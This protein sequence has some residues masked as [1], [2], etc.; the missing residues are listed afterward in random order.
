MAAVSPMAIANGNLASLI[1]GGCK[2][3]Q[4]AWCSGGRVLGQCPGGIGAPGSA[5]RR[6]RGCMLSRW[7]MLSP[8]VSSPAHNASSSKSAVQPS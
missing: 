1:A 6:T 8:V 7:A 3:A 5:I 4:V 2:D